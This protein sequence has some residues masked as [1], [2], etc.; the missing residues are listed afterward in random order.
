MMTK[1]MIKIVSRFTLNFILLII[2]TYFS[3]LTAWFAS[4]SNYLFFPVIYQL[5]DIHGY[6]LENAPKNTKEKDDFVFVSPGV[7]LKIFSDIMHSVNNNGEGLSD[8]T[9]PV[10]G[11]SKRFLTDGELTHLQEVSGFLTTLKSF[12]K[13]MLVVGVIAVSVM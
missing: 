7:H 5:E 11:G 1:I 12:W 3:L 2:L 6:V 13:L 9:Y 8:I 10:K 4:Y